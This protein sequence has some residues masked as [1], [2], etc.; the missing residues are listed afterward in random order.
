MDCKTEKLYSEGLILPVVECFYSLQGEG[1]NS[2]KSAF[3]IRLC[4]CNV[5]CSF[6]DS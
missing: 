2:G 1:Y 6:C 3:F 5:K 4:G